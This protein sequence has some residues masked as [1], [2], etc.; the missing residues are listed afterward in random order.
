MSAGLPVPRFSTARG[1]RNTTTYPDQSDLTVLL[2]L[3]QIVTV[4]VSRS[5][6]PRPGF[7]RPRRFRPCVPEGA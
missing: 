1:L 4:P 7:P 6:S 2:D 3:A 5:A